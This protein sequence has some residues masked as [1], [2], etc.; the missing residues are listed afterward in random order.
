MKRARGQLA[1]VA[2]KSQRPTLAEHLS[3]RAY[4]HLYRPGMINACPGCGRM[5]W[6]VGRASAEF[7][8]CEAV[9]PIASDGREGEA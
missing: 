8:F 9:V 2:V 7:A 4:R 1:L 3:R 6:W 5:H